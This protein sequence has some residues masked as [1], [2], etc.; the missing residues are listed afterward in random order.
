MLPSSLPVVPSSLGQVIPP[1]GIPPAPVTGYGTMMMLILFILVSVWIGVLANRATLRGGFMKG[2]FLGNRALGA[3]TLALTATVQS[4]GTFMGFPSLVYKHGWIVGLWIGSYMVIPITGFGIIGKRLAHLSRR[5]GAITVPDLFRTRF[6]SPNVGLTCTVFLLLYMSFLMFA[7]FKA[8]AIVMQLAWPGS[9][10]MSLAEDSAAETSGPHDASATAKIPNLVFEINVAGFKTPVTQYHI[11]LL[12]FTVTVVGYTLIGGFLGAVWTDLFQSILMFLGVMIL[13]YAS[14]TAAGGLENATLTSLKNT[15][16]GFVSGPGYST[17][18]N[19]TDFLPL[20]LAISFFIIWIWGGIG[21]PASLVRL[22]A[23]Q[24]TNVIRKSIYLLSIYNM[25]I[26]IPLIVICICGRALIPDLGKNSDE[27]IPRLALLTTSEWP[28]SSLVAGLILAAPFGAV[29]AT[30]SSYLVVISSAAVRDIYQRVINPK[31]E[32]DHLRLAAWG[33]MIFAGILSVVVNWNPVQFLQAFIV[34]STSGA[35]ATFLIPAI[36]ACY[37]RRAN[38]PGI[39]T[40]MLSGALTV[41]ILYVIGIAGLID[42]PIIGAETSFRPYFLLGYD[43][44]IWGLL[45]SIVSGV[46]VTM[47]TEPPDDD[48][49]ARMFDVISTAGDSEN[50]TSGVLP[51]QQS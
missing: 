14:L 26:Y 20:S 16:P 32:R 21:T 45:I 29:M 22:M 36:M 18:E 39:L 15:G 4:G 25:G 12:I 44:L 50:A 9:S 10:E 11:G 24:N 41:L 28:A 13:L 48:L 47:V 51:A 5:T 38:A 49:V 46:I 27:I 31:A 37:W 8:G 3:W 43:P 6:N 34:F 7:Q 30:V 23:S 40:S 17:G 42:Q 2:F 1:D 35:A 33:T 19:P